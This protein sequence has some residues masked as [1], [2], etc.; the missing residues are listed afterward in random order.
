MNN[1]KSNGKSAPGAELPPPTPE[2]VQEFSTIEKWVSRDLD[3]CIAFLQAIKQDVDLKKQ[4]ALWFHGRVVNY[5]NRPVEDPNQVKI[6][7]I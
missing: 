1:S 4:L 5:K 7:G 2:E 3:A 6:P